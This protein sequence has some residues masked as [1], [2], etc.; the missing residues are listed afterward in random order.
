M[1]TML[2]RIKLKNV[3]LILLGISMFTIFSNI[4]FYVFSVILFVL[5]MA[6]KVVG[7]ILIG[8]NSYY[9][10]KQIKNDEED[11]MLDEDKK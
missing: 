8:C 11:S 9:I 7:S 3:L 5:N 2:K 6:S 1:E 10:L 4:L